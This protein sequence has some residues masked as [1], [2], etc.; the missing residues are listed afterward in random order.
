MDLFSKKIYHEGVNYV[1]L[2]DRHKLKQNTKTHIRNESLREKFLNFTKAAL[3]TLRAVEDNQINIYR[4]W[5]HIGILPETNE[6]INEFKN[7]LIFCKHLDKLVGWQMYLQHFGI[8]DYLQHFLLKV[9]ENSLVF[10]E[11]IFNQKYINMEDFFYNDKFTLIFLVPLMNFKAFTDQ[12]ELEKN[13]EIVEINRETL[14]DIYFGRET[15]DRL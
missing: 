11:K 2:K 8:D 7:D 9:I 12:I 1:F 10:D 5:D 13:I 3:K 4:N 15:A 6:C 14:D